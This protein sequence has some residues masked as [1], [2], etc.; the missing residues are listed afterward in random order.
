MREWEKETER[1][2]CAK[3][4]SVAVVLNEASPVRN[5]VY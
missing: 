1:L 4:A 5:A 3:H 2:R